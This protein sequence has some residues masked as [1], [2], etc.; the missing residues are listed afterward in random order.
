[1]NP[2]AASQDAQQLISGAGQSQTPTSVPGA[3]QMAPTKPQTVQELLKEANSKRNSLLGDGNN[4]A[5]T[6]VQFGLGWMVDSPQSLFI[7]KPTERNYGIYKT[8]LTPFKD[9]KWWEKAFTGVDVASDAALVLGVA[10]MFVPIPGSRILGAGLISASFSSTVGK[11]AL[12]M[13]LKASSKAFAHDIRLVDS[14]AE[15]LSKITDVE[16]AQRELSNLKILNIKYNPTNSTV[17]DVLAP[18]IAKTEDIKT[19]KNVIKENLIKITD[20]GDKRV[21]E[22]LQMLSD[23]H[24]KR[25]VEQNSLAKYIKEGENHP[26]HKAIMRILGKEPRVV[27]AVTRVEGARIA[28]RTL[29][30]KEIP[31]YA[32]MTPQ[33]RISALVPHIQKMGDFK[34]GSSDAMKIATKVADSGDINNAV[35]AVMKRTGNNPIVR[36]FINNKLLSNPEV[37]KSLYNSSTKAD[38]LKVVTDPQMRKMIKA[39][40]SA[41]VKDLAK[42]IERG[43]KNSYID[44]IERTKWLSFVDYKG[45]A[46]DVV[47]AS[48]KGINSRVDLAQ[49]LEKLPFLSDGN[50][51]MIIR[52]LTDSTS[53]ADLKKILDL[54]KKKV[55]EGATKSFKKFELDDLNAYTQ[56][57]HNVLRKKFEDILKNQGTADV[58]AFRRQLNAYAKSR[59]M[60]GEVPFRLKH[61]IAN[62]SDSKNVDNILNTITD[63]STASNKKFIERQII[64][65][66]RKNRAFMRVNNTGRLSTV[67][68]LKTQIRKASLMDG[69]AKTNMIKAIDD[70]QKSK[71]ANP[72]ELHNSISQLMKYLE[73][74]S[75]SQHKYTLMKKM[76]DEIVGVMTKTIASNP[77]LKEAR[78]TEKGQSQG[79]LRRLVNSVKNVN[80]TFLGNGN[81]QYLMDNVIEEKNGVLNNLLSRGI[82]DS[83]ATAE[84]YNSADQRLFRGMSSKFKFKNADHNLMGV[85]QLM[86]RGDD[87]GAVRVMIDVSKRE[88]VMRINKELF[89]TWDGTREQYFNIIGDN[90]DA[91][92]KKLTRFY[93]DKLNDNHKEFLRVWNIKAGMLGRRINGVAVVHSDEAFGAVENYI[94]IS[95]NTFN[96]ETIIDKTKDIGN[97]FTIMHNGVRAA[98]S[99]SASFIKKTARSMNNDF[100][101]NTDIL[102]LISRHLDQAHF[103]VNVRPEASRVYRTILKLRSNPQSA[104]SLDQLGF[105]EDDLRK[106]VTR[107]QSIYSQNVGI[108]KAMRWITSR[109]AFGILA[110]KVSTVVAQFTA[111]P[112]F[113]GTFP[114][115]GAGVK[116]YLE[117]SSLLKG[118]LAEKGIYKFDLPKADGSRDWGIFDFLRDSTEFAGRERA[119]TMTG[120]FGG[121]LKASDELSDTHYRAP[122][123]FSDKVNYVGQMMLQPLKYTDQKLYEIGFLSAYIHQVKQAKYVLTKDFFKTPAMFRSQKNEAMALKIEDLVRATEKQI[124]DGMGSINVANKSL[125]L[126]QGQLGKMFRSGDMYA[127]SRLFNLFQ[128]F[129]MNSYSRVLTKGL[130]EPSRLWKA[131]LKGEAVSKMSSILLWEL[132]AKNLYVN[133]SQ[134]TYAV[135][136]QSLGGPGIQEGRNKPLALATEFASNVPVLG[137]A[138]GMLQQHYRTK[139]QVMPSQALAAFDLITNLADVRKAIRADGSINTRYMQDLFQAGGLTF[140]FPGTLQALQ[141]WKE[142]ERNKDP[143]LRT[144]QLLQAI[145]TRDK[146]QQANDIVSAF[147]FGNK[148]K[149][150]ALLADLCLVDSRRCTAMKKRIRKLDVSG[151]SR[152]LL[153]KISALH[154]TSRVTYIQN[155]FKKFKN[156]K[157]AQRFVDILTTGDLYKGKLKSAIQK[158]MYKLP[159]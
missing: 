90:F 80:L 122:R 137:V 52:R 158:E 93:K 6:G 98:S 10:S 67:R 151:A 155:K 157:D 156:K 5:Q 44:S 50:K 41:D 139:N 140:G 28:V 53:E 130:V 18:M 61:A 60:N 74:E 71:P 142:M 111:L 121:I 94:P 91:I 117:A 153:R 96:K 70:F 9:Q 24:Q 150:T 63:T 141:I 102:E 32:K 82:R 101:L 17:A 148:K 106:S 81:M 20:T 123:P 97:E 11:K 16:R 62:L 144:A 25:V 77:A 14:V 68:Y 152:G 31:D 88:D 83:I 132:I 23:V 59:F 99:V 129:V 43:M 112:E 87:A 125:F 143:D 69:K 12:E 4:L 40:K 47:K 86:R 127:V 79:W 75:A 116:A 147:A 84:Q 105:L 55:L 109:A 8:T 103:Y 119:N 136:S 124:S 92:K 73:S 110:G 27:G 57:W 26:V 108:N 36:D 49:R 29:L 107:G 48:F 128:T 118:P 56:R 2:F 46:N 126:S 131:G 39:N 76:N 1:M 72:Y 37:V 64:T 159:D 38:L 13:S 154:V 115:P 85:Y 114:T 35:E 66:H 21:K 95:Y 89:S 149:G 30:T 45:Q 42:M 33:E 15:K 58:I 145:D 65:E 134:A 146:Q 7:D 133:T 34:T 138:T 54:T 3:K 135:I 104:L 100:T 78:A 51:T 22:Y 19:I 120:G 113:L